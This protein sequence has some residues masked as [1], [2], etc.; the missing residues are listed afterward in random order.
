MHR[1]TRV[2]RASLTPA[3]AGEPLHAGP[4]FAAPFHTPGDP[5]AAPYTYAR[6]HN[7][8]WTELEA[9]IAAME[10]P[11]SH[12]RIFSSGMAAV[13]AVFGAVLRPGDIVVIPDNAYFGARTLLTGYFGE[14]GVVTRTVPTAELQDHLTD[15]RLLWLETPSNP[16]LEISDI[17]ALSQRA[18]R[19]GALVAVDNTTAT[20]FGQSP[21]TLG[22]DLSVASDS[23]AM[24]GH[25]DLLLGHVACTDRELLAAIDGFRTLHGAIVG[26]MEAWLAM[27]SLA[28]LPLRLE[29]TCA[30]AQ[31][32]ASFL[33]T[34]PEVSDVL[35]PGLLQH[36][37]HFIAARQ[38][39]HFGPVLG[40]TLPTQQ[41]AE[42]FLRRTQLITEATSFGGVLTTAERRARW[43]HDDIAPGFIRM[44]AGCEHIGDLIGDITQAL[45]AE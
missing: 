42:N 3:V 6:S 27:R 31:T 15:A 5:A 20:A 10:H 39:T 38:M 14:M 40:F 44:S 18:H 34:R 30:N 37:G 33:T 32:I 24:T 26:P 12:V 7:P 19:A 28:T 4:V 36:P 35:Y 16:T 2:I 41:V 9:A 45:E 11:G 23:K 29:R 22:A 21:L 8:G 17:A 25:S 43:G 13:A 1:I